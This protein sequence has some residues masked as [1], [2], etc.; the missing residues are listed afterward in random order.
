MTLDN[1]HQDWTLAAIK[2]VYRRSDYYAH[3]W[4]QMVVRYGAVEATKRQ[5]RNRP[6]VMDG[7]QR[8][9]DL[10]LDEYS[11]ECAVLNPRWEGLFSR[12]DRGIA[13]EAILNTLQQHGARAPQ[14]V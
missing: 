3:R 5:L 12:E 4:E 8:L 10:G 7:G 14:A 1:E 13:Y 9:T 2:E 6:A 11:I